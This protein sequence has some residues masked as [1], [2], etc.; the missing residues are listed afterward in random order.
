MFSYRL[1]F[2]ACPRSAGGCTSGTIG[3][4]ASVTHAAGL[5][6]CIEPRPV[7]LPAYE[8]K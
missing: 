1:S 6:A 2:L 4:N 8:L 3:A 7:T 5:A